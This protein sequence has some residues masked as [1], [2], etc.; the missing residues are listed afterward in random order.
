MAA[1]QQEIIE[2]IRRATNLEGKSLGDAG[3]ERRAE[4]G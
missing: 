3:Q 4:T 2:E 1:M